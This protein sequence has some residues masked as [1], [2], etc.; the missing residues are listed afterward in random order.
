M[1]PLVT[2]RSL[3]LFS[4]KLLQRRADTNQ[5]HCI[6]TDLL[7]QE[8]LSDTIEVGEESFGHGERLDNFVEE[9]YGDIIMSMEVGGKRMNITTFGD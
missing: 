8:E 2:C 4:Q 1:P 7:C 6:P 9:A 3:S 5:P